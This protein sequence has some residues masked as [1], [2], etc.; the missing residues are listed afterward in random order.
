[1]NDSLLTVTEAAEHLHLSQSTIYR[2]VKRELL[3]CIKKSFGLRFRSKEIEE[4]LDMSRQKNYLPTLTPQE[5]LT[6][7]SFER[8]D[9]RGI[10]ALASSRSKTRYDL[11]F[12]HIYQRRTKSGKVR[13]YLEYHDAQG[14]RIQKVAPLAIAKEEAAIALQEEV[15]G[16]FDRNYG[17]R[18]EQGKINFA[19]LSDMYLDN[20][21]KSNKK[22][23]KEDKY[24]IEARMKPYF[25]EFGLQDIN[26]LLLEKYRAER[27]ETGVTKSTV[28]RE[29]T[30]MK[31][32][33]N[34]AIDWEL[35]SENPV[36]KVKLFSEK[37]TA[38]ERILSGDEE[39]RLLSE[40]PGYLRPVLLTALNTGMRRGEILKLRWNQVDLGKKIIRVEHTKGGK[41]RLIPINDVLS[42]ELVKARDNS[43][44]SELV[45]PS[46]KT[47][48]PYTE[49]K[50][51]FKGACKRAEIE[52]M[53]FHDLR[54]T[55]ATRLIEEGVDLI[56][57]RDLLGHFSVRV[58]Q[59]YTHSNQNLKREAVDLL[60]AGRARKAENSA[61]LLHICD[62]GKDEVPATPLT[63]SNSIN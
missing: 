29:L 56:T 22:S 58:T 4:W 35:A 37:D 16:E 1:M 59:R 8:L 11:G 60:A 61:D 44:G 63:P 12:G 54:H 46:P 9:N 32:M 21:A 23:W 7:S 57:V 42:R 6:K 30:I 49:L 10:R 27:L 51:S 17:I 34:L 53:R 13:W 2:L 41:S 55:F 40:S 62:T 38:K 48:R 3:P 28:N 19:G 43:D 50:K 36:Q 25:G 31:K 24:R 26:P 15:K 45:F 14:K 20:Y 18:R 33:F 47:G 39:T 5:R 52:N